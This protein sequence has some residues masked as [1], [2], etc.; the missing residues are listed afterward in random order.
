MLQKFVHYIFLY[1]FTLKKID[2]IDLVAQAT[3]HTSTL[4]WGNGMD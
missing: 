3:Q 1:L 2:T 4:F